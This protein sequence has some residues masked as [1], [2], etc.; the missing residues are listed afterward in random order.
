M[1]HRSA[2]AFWRAGRRVMLVAAIAL[3]G[4]LTSAAPPLFAQSPPSSEADLLI[5]NGK[6][7]DGSGSP[8]RQGNIAIKGDTCVRSGLEHLLPQTLHVQSAAFEID[9]A[10]IWLRVDYRNSRPSL[11][12]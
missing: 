10:A 1:V 7:I 12:K 11:T 9:V 2:A 8:W 6:V 4:I 3:P 5:V